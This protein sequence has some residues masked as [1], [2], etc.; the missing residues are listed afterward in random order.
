MRTEKLKKLTEPM[1]YILLVAAFGFITTFVNHNRTP[2]LLNDSGLV[3]FTLEQQMDALLND[4][5]ETYKEVS[6]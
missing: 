5:H 3:S 6:L 4:Q 1:V 2:Q